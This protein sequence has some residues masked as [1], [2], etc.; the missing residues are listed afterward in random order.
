MIVTVF[1]DVNNWFEKMVV[2]FTLQKVLKKNGFGIV[3]EDFLDL[4][5]LIAFLNFSSILTTM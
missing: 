3:Q 5:K 4:L 1:P 2:Y